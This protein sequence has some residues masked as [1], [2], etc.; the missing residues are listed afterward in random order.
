MCL[1]RNV[2][3][4]LVHVG[5]KLRKAW[6]RRSTPPVGLVD[7]DGKWVMISGPGH[8]IGT[9]TGGQVGIPSVFRLCEGQDQ[10]PVLVDSECSGGLGMSEDVRK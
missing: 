8:V 2:P 3:R 5:W 9:F 10:I 6:L 4:V 1:P 7:S